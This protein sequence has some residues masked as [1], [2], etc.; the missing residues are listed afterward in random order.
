M[1]IDSDRIRWMIS[2]VTSL[3]QLYINGIEM[4]IISHPVFWF[5]NVTENF[6]VRRTS[7]YSYS[8]SMF[9]YSIIDRL[10]VTVLYD[11]GLPSSMIVDLR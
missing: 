9:D 8:M 1:R 5:A 11:T 6:S 3:I 10:V 7:T 4:E 2:V